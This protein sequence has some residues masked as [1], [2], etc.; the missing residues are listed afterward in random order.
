M[1]VQIAVSLPST[2][3]AFLDHCVAAVEAPT[4]AALITISLERELRHRLAM[5]DTEIL[6]QVGPAD[7]L[8]DLVLWSGR[9]FDDL[10]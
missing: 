4:R 7:E 5:R 3:V 9:S 6:S 8:D 1:S 2:A 10:D